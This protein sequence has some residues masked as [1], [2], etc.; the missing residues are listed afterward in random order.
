MLNTHTLDDF[1]NALLQLDAKLKQLDT[2]V[3]QVRVI[4][5]LVPRSADKKDLLSLL[6]ALDVHDIVKTLL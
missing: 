3:L 6:N 1:I 4:G 2:D 5:G